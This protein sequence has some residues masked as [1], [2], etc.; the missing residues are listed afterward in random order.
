VDG[1]ANDSGVE[2]AD[3]VQLQ[4]RGASAWDASFR[5]AQAELSAI[6]DRL[7]ATYA[8]ENRS[9][10]MMVQPLKEALTGDSRGTLM[11]LWAARD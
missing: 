7:H 6:S 11:F 2:V 3:S 8:K 10:E 9:K 1:I 4:G 5:S